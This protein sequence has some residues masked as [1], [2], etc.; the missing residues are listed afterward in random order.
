VQHP[1]CL[2]WACCENAAG[3]GA[4]LFPH[5]AAI[6]ECAHVL[7]IAGCAPEDVCEP[8]GWLGLAHQWALIHRAWELGHLRASESEDVGLFLRAHAG[9]SSPVGSG[10]SHSGSAAHRWASVGSFSASVIGLASQCA[11]LAALSSARVTGRSTS[12]RGWGCAC[13]VSFCLSTE[14][15]TWAA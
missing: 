14:S 9:E 12:A 8:R 1:C 2:G 5:L 15:A 6:V 7:Q 4:G 10:P 11:A 3:D 13:L